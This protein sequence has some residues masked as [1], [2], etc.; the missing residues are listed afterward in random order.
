MQLRLRMRKTSMWMQC[1][2]ATLSQILNPLNVTPVMGI[3][4]LPECLLEVLF[5]IFTIRSLMVISREVWRYLLA[6]GAVLV[7][8]SW[9]LL[10]SS[11]LLW[12][13]QASKSAARKLKFLSS[14]F[15]LVCCPLSPPFYFA[16][17]WFLYFSRCILL[18]GPLPSPHLFCSSLQVF[19][20]LK[21]MLYAAEDVNV[22]PHSF[23]VTPS[24]ICLL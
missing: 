20:M 12:N 23:I 1:I 17:P 15:S 3:Y 6:L 22:G 13:S 5:I 19:G 4:Y 11:C 24:P 18:S 14:P 21:L 10:K 7:A 16:S 2:L 8:A 9:R